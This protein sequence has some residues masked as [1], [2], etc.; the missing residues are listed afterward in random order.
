MNG[1]GAN[2]QLP[3]QGVY[4][5]HFIDQ[6]GKVNTPFFQNLPL[7]DYYMENEITNTNKQKNKQ[8]TKTKIKEEKGLPLNT[9]T[10]YY[11]ASER[12]FLRF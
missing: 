11:V 6:A 2:L 4:L 8:K 1:Q 3:S 12:I 5:K 10:F 7:C 9:M